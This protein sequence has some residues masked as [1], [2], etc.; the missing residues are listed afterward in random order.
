MG[1]S[2][3]QTLQNIGVDYTKG[4]FSQLVRTAHKAKRQGVY[5]RHRERATRGALMDNSGKERGLRAPSKKPCR[6]AHRPTCRRALPLNISV[7][8][9]TIVTG[10]SVV[11]LCDRGSAASANLLSPRPHPC[12]AA[13]PYSP[14][15][16]SLTRPPLFSKLSV[17][18]RGWVV[19]RCVCT[20][21]AESAL[22]FVISF[23]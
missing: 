5:K 1:G 6:W 7:G 2:V 9:V 12:T 16:G 22:T 3:P 21:A 11:R 19:L 18:F 8:D 17:R 14:R 23:L 20:P 15:A 13:E 4:I 10:L